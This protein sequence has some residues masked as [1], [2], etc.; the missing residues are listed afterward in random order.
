MKRNGTEDRMI[1]AI[2][3]KM[4]FDEMWPKI[5]KLMQD[6]GTAESVLKKSES[7]AAVTLVQLL[8][9]GKD[10][11]RRAAAK[12]IIERVSGKAV[13]RSLNVNVSHLAEQDL[14]SQIN[15]L[16]AEMQGK[17]ALKAHD[18]KAEKK[19]TRRQSRKPRKD[20]IPLEAELILPPENDGKA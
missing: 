20:R 10:E 8:A 2:Q 17:R 11:V 3:Q 4:V 1:K 6:G 12:D 7:L 14:D 15:R 18:A 19:L 13:E 5:Q 16:L 9:S